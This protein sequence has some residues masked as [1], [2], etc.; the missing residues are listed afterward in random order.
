MP[1]RTPLRF[2]YPS[3]IGILLFLSACSH[4]GI[5]AGG[6]SETNNGGIAFVAMTGMLIVMAVVL[7]WIIGRED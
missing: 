7:W 3:A 5:D 1:K 4:T 6:E 2:L